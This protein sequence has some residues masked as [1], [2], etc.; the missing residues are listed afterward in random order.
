MFLFIRNFLIFIFCVSV[1]TID[2]CY[3][4]YPPSDPLVP[5]FILYRC[6]CI[7][8]I[9]RETSNRALVMILL[10]LRRCEMMSKLEYMFKIIELIALLCDVDNAKIGSGSKCC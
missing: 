4:F 1:T 2:I 5:S 6:G 9:R 7:L 8:R 10:C 3:F